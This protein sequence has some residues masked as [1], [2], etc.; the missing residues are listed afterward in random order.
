MAGYVSEPVSS[1]SCHVASHHLS[2]RTRSRL[3]QGS[4]GGR[5]REGLRV[6]IEG[7]VLRLLLLL[8]ERLEVLWVL[9]MCCLTDRWWWRRQGGDGECAGL[10]W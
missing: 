9:P 5:G 1:A 2:C 3:E 6:L 7:A 10:S 4:T 8:L